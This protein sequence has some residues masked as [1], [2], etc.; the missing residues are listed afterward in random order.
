MQ[1]I[2]PLQMNIGMPAFKKCALM[3][4]TAMSETIRGSDI[5]FRRIHPVYDLIDA[6]SIHMSP[7]NV[8]AARGA[9]VPWAAFLL[10]Q[11]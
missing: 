8:N 4:A 6:T 7:V 11:S 1:I 9:D 5:E 2:S 3:N 10:N